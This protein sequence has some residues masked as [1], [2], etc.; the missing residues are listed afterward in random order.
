M[1]FVLLPVSYLL[2]PLR[3]NQELE[4][5]GKP[6]TVAVSNVCLATVFIDEN[7]P[8]FGRMKCHTPDARPMLHAVFVRTDVQHSLSA[9]SNLLK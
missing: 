3:P 5:E 9:I 2:Q 6:D 8:P 4:H 1:W 7:E